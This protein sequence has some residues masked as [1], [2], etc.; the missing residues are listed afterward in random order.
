MY[1]SSFQADLTPIPPAHRAACRYQSAIIHANGYSPH[2]TPVP[3]SLA[4][5]PRATNTSL[6]E[7]TPGIIHARA[8][9]VHVASASKPS[10]PA[11]FTGSTTVHPLQ[12]PRISQEKQ[13][14]HEALPQ[15]GDEQDATGDTN[16][17]SPGFPNTRLLRPQARP[18]R[19]WARSKQRRLERVLRVGDLRDS[20]P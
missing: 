18:L 8:A 3:C 10:R 9:R 17:T 13:S 2:A 19:P 1:C 12:I 7:P 4:C 20:F 11:N 15:A 5:F 16:Y 14:R 6:R